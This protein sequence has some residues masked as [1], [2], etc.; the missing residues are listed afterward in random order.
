MH[1]T[2]LAGHF[3]DM[4][5]VEGA[6]FED[7]REAHLQQDWYPFHGLHVLCDTRWNR[8]AVYAQDSDGECVLVH[9]NI[10]K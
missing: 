1:R 6:R 10:Q 7:W 4:L 8:F 3:A 2:E 9:T 5:E